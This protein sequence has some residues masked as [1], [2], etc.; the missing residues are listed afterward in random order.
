V[1]KVRKLLLYSLLAILATGSWTA[2][3]QARP[4][5]RGAHSPVASASAL[6][7]C[8]GN[9]GKSINRLIAGWKK[10]HVWDD[11]Q[12][13]IRAMGYSSTDFPNVRALLVERTVAVP[14]SKRQRLRNTRCVGGHMRSFGTRVRPRGYLVRVFLP[15]S[16]SRKDICSKVSAVCKKH[17]R[18]LKALAQL[19]CGNVS[20]SVVEVEIIV[21]VV[22]EEAPKPPKPQP[23]PQPSPQ[24]TPIPQPPMGNCNVVV[25]GNTGTVNVN[26][27]NYTI[28]IVCSGVNI[29]FGGPNV[30][31]VNQ[32]VKQY[33]ESH[34]CNV[35]TPP[36]TP[37]PTP[38]PSP[39]PTPTPPPKVKVKLVKF[40]FVDGNKVECPKDFG[41]SV[42]GNGGFTNSGGEVTNL[43][44]VNSG[45]QVTVCETD[46]KGWTRD[47][48]QCQTVTTTG[49]DAT[50]TF[51][52]K[53]VTPPPPKA[54]AKLVKKAF[55]D[56]S[57]K[58]LTGGQF[59]FSVSV[60]GEVKFSTTN[61]ASGSSR[62]LGDFNAGD[63][64]KVCETNSDG[65]TPDDE[66]I[67]HTMVAD[68]TFTFTVINRKTT[69]K[70]PQPH[71][72]A[73]APCPSSGSVRAVTVT[74]TNTGNADAVNVAVEVTGASNSPASFTVHPGQTLTPTFSTS[75]DIDVRVRAMFGS[76]TLFDQTFP[77][78]EQPP[79]PKVTCLTHHDVFSGGQIDLEIKA[80]FADGTQP[81]LTPDDV[82]F[83]ADEGNMMDGT[84]HTYTDSSGTYWVQR[85]QAPATTIT[86]VASWHASV[87][88]A[89][90]PCSNDN[91][92]VADSGW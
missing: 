57:S 3:A 16:L 80:S 61:A 47:G 31:E 9:A 10:K 15:Q 72:N 20:P 52:N 74:L 58:T 60:N 23:Q 76:D 32:A 67:P 33:E 38:T 29:T 30:N 6:F 21:V 26:Q 8:G 36:P 56:G 43:V 65:F 64:V 19:A 71:A 42:N 68:E 55:V 49:S 77:K 84:K 62:D 13:R 17:R 48:D 78:C 11:V 79:K 40:C 89:E 18:K 27:C 45:T 54:H 82:Q 35:V 63:V 22:V 25:S 66:C 5:E 87:R 34:N 39:T 91:N 46:P 69:P 37:T 4:T 88:G 14:L 50:I 28:I 12:R 7:D 2:A 83:W 41:F 59:S 85:W 75:T 44:E 90:A 86:H 1:T 92:V 70:V 53:K 51:K 24:P 81:T 73:S